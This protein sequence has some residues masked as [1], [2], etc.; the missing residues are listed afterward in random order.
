MNTPNSRQL[1]LPL[2]Q[3]MGLPVRDHLQPVLDRAEEAVRDSQVRRPPR[4]GCGR[5]GP[6]ARSA[7]SVVGS[8]SPGSRPPHT[9]CNV[10][11]RNSISRMPPSPELD[12]MAGYAGQGI[13]VRQK[14]AA[15]VRVDAAL[16][17]VDV[18]DGGEIEAA[19]PDEGPDVL[20]EPRA[21]L[22]IPRHGPRLRHRGAFPV[23]AH[24]FVVGDRGRQGDRRRRRGGIGAEAQVGAEHV[25]VRVPRFHEGDEVCA[26]SGCRQAPIASSPSRS[27]Y[28]PA[29]GS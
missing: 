15:L 22:Q 10:C 14:R 17:R 12:V 13:A 3:G 7:P 21:K 2:R 4:A 27:M 5:T 11:A 29:L 28:T 20:Q 23:L 8:R 9:S 18:G 1:F 24:A 6:S 25:A 26:R 16:H 19:A